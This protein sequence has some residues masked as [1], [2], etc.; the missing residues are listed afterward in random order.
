[1][2]KI[3]LGILATMAGLVA[4]FSYRTSVDV[5]PAPAPG[6]GGRTSGSS[7]GSGTL[8]DGSFDGGSAN[9]RYG[10]VDVKITVAAGKIT[11]VDVPVYPDGNGVDRQINSVAIPQ[12]VTETLSA[13]SSHIDMVSGA[14]FTSNGYVQSLQ[15]A[16]DQAAA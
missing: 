15:S 1:M 2:K 16:L 12:L 11:A 4:L 8:K 6:A 3:V 9:T 13:Q 10:P 14:T 5:S 7:S